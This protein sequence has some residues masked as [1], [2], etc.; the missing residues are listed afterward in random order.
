MT[1][2]NPTTERP[3]VKV[4]RTGH[5]EITTYADGIIT[6]VLHSTPIVVVDV[7]AQTVTLDNGGWNTPTT[8]KHVND[9]LRRLRA[10][11]GDWM[12]GDHAHHTGRQLT[13]GHGAKPGTSSNPRVTI[14]A[15]DGMVYR[16]HRDPDTGRRVG[17]YHPAPG[18]GGYNAAYG[19]AS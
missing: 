19:G 1:T 9:A 12:P 6:V 13:Y 5:N 7:A 11:L 18:L 16:G 2:T 10:E 4:G 14:V 3:P 17:A 15:R 8:T